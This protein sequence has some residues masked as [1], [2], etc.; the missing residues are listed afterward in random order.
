MCILHASQND[1]VDTVC[2]RFAFCTKEVVDGQ[3]L[4]V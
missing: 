1:D 2:N 3:G 4:A